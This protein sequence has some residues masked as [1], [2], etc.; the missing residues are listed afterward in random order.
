MP[1]RTS[2]RHPS[3]ESQFKTLKQHAAFPKR[4]G[5]PQDAPT[6]SHPTFFTAFYQH[7]THSNIP[8]QHPAYSLIS[9]PYQPD[10]AHL[11]FP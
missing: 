9:T 3:S 4:F 8:P 5:C 11:T 7:K 6:G 2:R 1:A 10:P